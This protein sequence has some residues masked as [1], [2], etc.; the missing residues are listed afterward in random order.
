MDWTCWGSLKGPTP[1]CGLEGHQCSLKRIQKWGTSQN[2]VRT[3]NRSDEVQISQ[4]KFRRITQRNK[5]ANKSARWFKL[6]KVKKDLKVSVY[7]KSDRAVFQKNKDIIHRIIHAAR[8]LRK[9]PLQLQ[10][11]AGAA[12]R[13]NQIAQGFIL[14]GLENLKNRLDR[15]CE[16]PVHLLACKVLRGIQSLSFIFSTQSDIFSSQSWLCRLSS[17][18]NCFSSQQ[19]QWAFAEF[20]SI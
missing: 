17:E 6:E 3:E 14:S 12:V 9:V 7:F 8:K 1:C 10:L 15:L 18:G 19:S 4:M 20:P 13:W 2:G 16:Q 5:I 11:K